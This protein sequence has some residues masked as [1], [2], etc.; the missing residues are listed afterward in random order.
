MKRTAARRRKDRAR[1]RIRR[2]HY[3]EVAPP[4]GRTEHT[5]LIDDAC[6]FGP[7]LALRAAGLARIPKHKSVEEYLAALDQAL[8]D[9]PECDRTVENQSIL[10]ANV[11]RD[12]LGFPALP[13]KVHL[14]PGTCCADEQR[15]ME[16]G[17]VSCGDPCL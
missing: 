9:L 17:C 7:M 12:G 10:L 2:S 8:A 14:A 15:S 5:V 3:V 6:D 16:G 13:L 1:N 4:R 11:I